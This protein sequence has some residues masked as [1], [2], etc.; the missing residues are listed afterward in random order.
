MNNT[1]HFSISDNSVLFRKC[2]L[3]SIKVLIIMNVLASIDVKIRGKSDVRIT[4]VQLENVQLSLK[5]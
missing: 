3:C 2:I 4:E 1:V 5:T